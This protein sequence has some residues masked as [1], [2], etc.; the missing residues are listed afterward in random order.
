MISE[1]YI[2]REKRVAEC[3]KRYFDSRPEL[4]KALD[5]LHDLIENDEI[6]FEEFR[7]RALEAEKNMVKHLTS[8]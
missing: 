2:E 7:K 4:K 5:E 8:N 6:S 1:E 3:Y